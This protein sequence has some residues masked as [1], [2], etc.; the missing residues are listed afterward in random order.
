[1]AKSPI[2]NPETWISDYFNLMFSKTS[3]NKHRVWGTNLKRS[4][5]NQLGGLCRYRNTKD[6]ERIIKD[7][8]NGLEPRIWFS[9]PDELNDPYD[10]Q[11]P[12]ICCEI[13][14]IFEETVKACCTYLIDREGISE[15]EVMK[16]LAECESNLPT[17][18]LGEFN[19]C[20]AKI[21]LQYSRKKMKSFSDCRQF[22]DAVVQRPYLE[23]CKQKQRERAITCFTEK[24]DSILMWSHYAENHTGVCLYYGIQTLETYQMLDKGYLMEYIHPVQY[25]A[26]AS[27]Q[28]AMFRDLVISQAKNGKYNRND[29]LRFSMINS[30][31]KSL[32]WSYEQEWR[33]VLNLGQIEN[34][35]EIMRY[36]RVKPDCIYLGANISQENEEKLCRLAEENAI[37]VKKMFLT[38]RTYKL[39]ARDL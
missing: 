24:P 8:E 13:P 31:T 27:E 6:I 32:D 26:D 39:V 35:P 23:I 30:L 37:S 15:P 25:S 22:V 33:M 28:I 34:P 4:R 3:R 10:S 9:F 18:D 7:L 16:F 36:L 38:D 5:L 21:F 11:I 12:N 1:M 19:Y 2:F 14:S 29:A 20:L 17:D